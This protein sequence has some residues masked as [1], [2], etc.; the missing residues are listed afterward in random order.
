MTAGSGGSAAVPMAMGIEFGPGDRSHMSEE[1]RHKYDSYYRKLRNFRNQLPSHLL[2]KLSSTEI[3][4]LATS[5]MDGT[6]FEI[7]GELEDIQKL[8]ERSLLKTRMEVVN[9][10]K[11]KKVELSKRHHRVLIG[12]ESKPHTVPLLKEKQKAELDELEKK[13]AEEMRSVDKKIILE[14]DQLVADQQSTMQQCAVPVFS[15]TNCPQDVQLQMYLLR[16]LKKM[17]A[18]LA[19]KPQTTPNNSALF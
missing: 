16:F 8:T 10:H 13:L 6:V 17:K 19:P 15:I 12:A 18:S 7:V 9:R 11:G 3:R 1:D 14:F 2:L 4:E 5:L